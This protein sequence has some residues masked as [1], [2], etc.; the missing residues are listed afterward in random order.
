MICVYFEDNKLGRVSRWFANDE[1]EQAQEVISALH[2]KGFKPQVRRFTEEQ[3]AGIGR[4][5]SLD[6]LLDEETE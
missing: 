1:K 3:V 6:G 2:R 4:R 5:G